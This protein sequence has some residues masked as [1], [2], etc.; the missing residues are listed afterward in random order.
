MGVVGLEVRR[1]Y[2]EVPQVPDAQLLGPGPV[3]LSE[4][5]RLW[6][7]PQKKHCPGATPF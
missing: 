7:C 3:G 1:S 6:S 4:V 2:T 5:D